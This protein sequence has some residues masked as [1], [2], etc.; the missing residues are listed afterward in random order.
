MFPPLDLF[1]DILGGLGLASSGSD[2]PATNWVK[3]ASGCLQLFSGICQL[4]RFRSA[5]SFQG[6][7]RVCPDEMRSSEDSCAEFKRDSFGLEALNPI[8]E[9]AS[10][11]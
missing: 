2:C 5:M 8:P 3:G 7:C 1:G 6:L 9:Y 4:L 10:R 11:I